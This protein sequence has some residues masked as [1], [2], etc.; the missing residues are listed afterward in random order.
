M[1]QEEIIEGNKLIGQFMG[2]EDNKQADS[3][4]ASYINDN[5]LNF[6]DEDYPETPHD[7]SCWKI[8]DLKYH[9]DWNWLMGVVKK[10]EETSPL[11]GIVMIQQGM[12]KITPR[13]INQH[14][15]ISSND[16]YLYMGVK[17]KIASTYQS[18]IEYIKW[19]N[20]QSK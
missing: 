1:T 9:S 7:G 20:T 6:Q 10:I 17:G 16:N 13:A 18:V 4:I 3:W 2:G 5:E 15:I 8:S 12:C 19:Y 14:Q 11:G